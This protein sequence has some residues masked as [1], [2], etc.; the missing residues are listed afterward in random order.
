MF[1]ILIPVNCNVSNVEN[2]TIFHLILGTEILG[3]GCYGNNRV[4][5][6]VSIVFH[7]SPGFIDVSAYTFISLYELHGICCS[8][9][10]SPF[11]HDLIMGRGD[12]G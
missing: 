8:P 9:L 5:Q 12:G 4:N 1:I 11:N 6:E 2:D 3:S 7:T 10:S